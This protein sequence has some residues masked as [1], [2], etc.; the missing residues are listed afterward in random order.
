MRLRGVVISVLALALAATLAGCTTA[1][2][3][4]SLKIKVTGLPTGVDAQVKV[5]GPGGYAKTVTSATTLSLAPGTYAVAGEPARNGD[6]VVSTLYAG[7]ASPAS[8]TVTANATSSSTVSYAM[9]TGSGHL[10]IP[11][12]TPGGS[13]DEVE[14][15]AAGDLASSG[16]PS[17]DVALATS[18]NYGESVA[19]DGAGNLLVIDQG[20]IIYRFDAAQLGTS[21]SPTPAVT[22]DASAY[23]RFYGAAFDASGDLWTCSLDSDQLIMF[24]PA[25]LAAGGT[26]TPAVV[27]DANGASLVRPYALAFDASGDLWVANLNGGAVVEF[28]P[29]QLASSGSPVQSV[30]LGAATGGIT[31]PAGLAFD[32]AGNLWVANFNGG[33]DRFD[34]S[35]LTTSGHPVAAAVIGAAAGSNPSGVAIDASGALWVLDENGG[36]PAVLRRFTSPDSLSGSVSPS[37]DVTLTSL[38]EVDGG[39]LAFDPPPAGLP[40]LTP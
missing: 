25:Q 7:S 6:A 8:V 27:I 28:T 38:G 2:P 18:T 30:R 13:A 14:G 10:W 12:W 40:I 3:T 24:T 5:T 15:Y 17:A 34:A 35:Q 23:A 21:G 33:V 36:S 19:L 20:G 16:T 37:P 22:I 11:N 32:A 39:D 31:E 29:A 1:S 26:V 9:R 4:G